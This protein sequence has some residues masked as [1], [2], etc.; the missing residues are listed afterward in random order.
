MTRWERPAAAGLW[1]QDGGRRGGFQA[2]EEGERDEIVQRVGDDGDEE[3]A[4]HQEQPTKVRA[5]DAGEERV[6]G[7]DPVGDAE[8]RGGERR[9]RPT[10]GMCLARAGWMTP[11]KSVSSPSPANSATSASA[12]GPLPANIGAIRRSATCTSRA[13][14]GE[15]R[16]ETPR[17]PQQQ[18]GRGRDPPGQAP[19]C[20]CQRRERRQLEPPSHGQREQHQPALA[21]G[22][23]P[24]RAAA[25]GRAVYLARSR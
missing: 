17:E 24:C 14:G 25:A 4:A 16:V 12:S 2:H 22:R 5:D 19:P 9:E 7:R 15:A 13:T 11:R 10:W 18:R 3:I 1:L 8:Q 23:E 21:E 6:R 20:P